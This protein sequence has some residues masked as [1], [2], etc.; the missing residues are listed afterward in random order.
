[1]PYRGWLDQIRNVVNEWQ[2]PCVVLG[3]LVLTGHFEA[4]LVEHGQL[5]L[6]E[7]ACGLI[8]TAILFPKIMLQ[9]YSMLHSRP[10]RTHDLLNMSS[11]PFLLLPHLFVVLHSLDSLINSQS[12]QIHYHVHVSCMP[13]PFP[14]APILSL[15]SF[16]SVTR[17]AFPV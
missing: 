9:R 14:P 15:S 11:I 1:M 10:A 16:P 7:A 4:V 12:T 8:S 3:D 5:L 2:R 13:D 17:R 6:R